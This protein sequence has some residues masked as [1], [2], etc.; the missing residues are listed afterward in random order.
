MKI[1]VKD[2]DELLDD[3]ALHVV[4]LLKKQ[5][6]L[7]DKV[8]TGEAKDS[9]KY[10]KNDRVV[11]SKTDFVYN[12][13]YGRLRGNYVPLKPLIEWVKVKFNVTND[14]EAYVLAKKLNEKILRDGIPA[15][16]FMKNVLEKLER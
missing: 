9:I 14:R 10:Y 1:N 13:E 6:E 15:S 11:G 16:R 5:L 3:F 2:E 8:F 12:I 7:Q 4:D